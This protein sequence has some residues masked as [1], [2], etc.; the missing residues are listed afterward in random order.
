[1]ISLKCLN[2]TLEFSSA[3]TSPIPLC[4]QRVDLNHFLM[5]DPIWNTFARLSWKIFSQMDQISGK[6]HF[7]VSA[8]KLEIESARARFMIA[9]RFHLSEI[10]IFP[11]WFFFVA[12]VVVLL[13]SQSKRFEDKIRES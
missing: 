7:G 6:N 11:F 5:K 12:F 4:S 10:N 1:M 9:F 3:E 8:G 2:V 13:V